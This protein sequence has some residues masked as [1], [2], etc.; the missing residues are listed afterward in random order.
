MCKTKYTV[1]R[2][3]PSGKFLATEEYWVAARVFVFGPVSYG[4]KVIKVG[5]TGMSVCLMVLVCTGSPAKS[6]GAR[7]ACFKD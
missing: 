3:D 4:K 7:E 2:K 6:G 5:I 1:G